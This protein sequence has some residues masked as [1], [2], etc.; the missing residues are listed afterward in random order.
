[1]QVWSINLLFTR[2]EAVKGFHESVN[3]TCVF[4]VS[5]TFLLALLLA[6]LLASASYCKLLLAGISKTFFEVDLQFSFDA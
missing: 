5:W 1:M 3:L 6:S 4:R 2:Q